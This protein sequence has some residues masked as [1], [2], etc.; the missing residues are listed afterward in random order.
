MV[1]YRY[2]AMVRIRKIKSLFID[3]FVIEASWGSDQMHYVNYPWIS[4]RNFT[5]VRKGNSLKSLEWT[6]TYYLAMQGDLKIVRLSP[7]RRIFPQ[8]VGRCK[9]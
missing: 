3:S 1:E 7:N 6:Q 4:A 5:T 8:L 2:G 9:P